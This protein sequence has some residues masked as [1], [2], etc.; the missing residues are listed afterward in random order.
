MENTIN[1]YAIEN[2]R[3]LEVK[4]DQMRILKKWDAKI[5]DKSDS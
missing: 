4:R 3:L 5:T 2:K 1:A